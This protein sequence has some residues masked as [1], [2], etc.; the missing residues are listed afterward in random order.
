LRSIPAREESAIQDTESWIFRI[1]Q[2]EPAHHV[3][4]MQQSRERRL[5]FL[6]ALLITRCPNPVKA[7]RDPS[8][9][10]D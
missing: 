6:D 7:K 9:L 10:N 5:S 4:N 3:S 8:R 1:E 2:D